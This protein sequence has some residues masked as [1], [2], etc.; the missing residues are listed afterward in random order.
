MTQMDALIQIL[1]GMGGSIGFAFL[2]NIRGRHLIFAAIGGFMSWGMFL[3]LGLWIGDEALRYLL[4]SAMITVYSEILARKLKAPACIFC[5]VSLIPL[6]PGGALYY[7]A[8]Y[9]LSA[10]SA[11]FIS[12]AIYTLKLSVGLSL[13]I[14]LVTVF[15]RYY[16]LIQKKLKKDRN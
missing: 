8:Q 13:G 15:F 2:F 6:V 4:V 14:V 7:S 5:I 9:A 12:K 1:T 3:L 11:L 10:D 16:S